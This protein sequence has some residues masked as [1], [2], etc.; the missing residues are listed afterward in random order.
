M[1]KEKVEIKINL[2]YFKMEE[3]NQPG[4]PESHKKMD[5][6]LLMILDNMRHRSKIPYTITSGYRSQEYNK[7]IG[8]AKN[9]SHCK[10]MAVDIAAP[11]STTKYSIIEAALHFG[12]QRIG[13]GSN[14][15]HIDID[16]QDKA[17][18]VCWTY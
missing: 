7:K 11:D 8:G 16:D 4:L 2:H 1:E 15:I 18:K 5:T 10:G 9:S 13:V 12:I 14:F 3:F 17:A 6:N